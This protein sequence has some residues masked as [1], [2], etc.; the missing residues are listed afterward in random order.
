MFIEKMQIY[1]QDVKRK[2]ILESEELFL[3]FLVQDV[4][5]DGTLFSCCIEH[6]DYYSDPT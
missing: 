4:H 3:L 6:N 5:D 2:D 1:C